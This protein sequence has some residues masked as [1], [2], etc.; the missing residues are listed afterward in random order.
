MSV[1]RG[2]EEEGFLFKEAEEEGTQEEWR[3]SQRSGC[4]GDGGRRGKMEAEV[5][6]VRKTHLGEARAR[7][8]NV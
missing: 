6:P 7:P 4:G 8:A 2:G 1:G 5:Q 3:R